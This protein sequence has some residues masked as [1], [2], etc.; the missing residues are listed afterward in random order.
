[1]LLPVHGLRKQAKRLADLAL[2]LR[3]DVVLLCELGLA[4]LGRRGGTAG[5]C[6]ALRRLR[7]IC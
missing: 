2:L 5:G 4:G 6:F 1:M 3:R 7:N